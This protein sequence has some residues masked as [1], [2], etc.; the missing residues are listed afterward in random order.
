MDRP[1]Q[2][3]VTFRCPPELEA[4]LPRPMPAMLGLPEW[5][6]A[7]PQKTFSE[8]GQEEVLTI[9]RSVRPSSTRWPMDS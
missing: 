3:G 1:N 4:I 6:K 2:Y 9:K 7:L 5:F 8:I